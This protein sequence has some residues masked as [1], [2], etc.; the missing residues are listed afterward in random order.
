M[1][2]KNVGELAG[3]GAGGHDAVLVVAEF[4]L[5][6]ERRLRSLSCSADLGEQLGL[7]AAGPGSVPFRGG[8][9][10]VLEVDLGGEDAAGPVGEFHRQG[11][12]QAPQ[13]HR[14]VGD[15]GQAE[16]LAGRAVDPVPEPG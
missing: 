12:A 13:V 15:R 3:A 8:D 2:A 6:H 5:E 4:G 14:A 7:G 9:G 11:S 16:P 10:D 1:L